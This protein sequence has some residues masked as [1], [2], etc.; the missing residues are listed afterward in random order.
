M[1][2]ALAAWASREVQASVVLAGTATHRRSVA[3]SV[4]WRIGLLIESENANA[5]A[6]LFPPIPVGSL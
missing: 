4:A 6:A 5:L 2:I 3:A 1:K